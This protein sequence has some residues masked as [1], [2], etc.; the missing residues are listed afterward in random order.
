MINE[1][2][3]N[4]KGITLISLVV[5]I[6]VLMIV[7]N[8]IIYYAKDNLKVGKLKAMQSDIANLRDKISSYYAQN[9]AIPAK[10]KYTNINH[11]KE[12][13][14]IS[15]NVDIGDFYVI[16]LSALEN[17]TLNYGRDFEKVKEDSENSKQYKDL[18]IINETSHNIFYVEGIQVDNDIFYT[19]YTKEE[20]DTKAVSLR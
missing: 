15:S 5:A 6:A 7:S 17:L 8:I 20:I 12:S 14:V 3:K 1:K 11:I 4:A 18:Y 16:D 10:I 2:N 19:D 13:G 9:G